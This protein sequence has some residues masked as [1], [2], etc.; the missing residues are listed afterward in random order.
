VENTI[1]NENEIVFVFRKLQ[2]LNQ[3]SNKSDLN[4]LIDKTMVENPK[5]LIKYSK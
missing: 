4:T 5:N 2:K 3:Q 1:E